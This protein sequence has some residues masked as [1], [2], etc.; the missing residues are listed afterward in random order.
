MEIQMTKSKTQQT[1]ASY[2]DG[3]TRAF[4]DVGAKVQ[5]PEAAR[6]FFRTQAATASQRAEDLHRQ[7]KSLADQSKTAFG[8]FAGSFDTVT[9]AMLDASLANTQ[10]YFATIEKLADANSVGEALTIQADYVR[11]ATAAN[12]ERIRTGADQ[13]K[14]L[15][16]EN[17]KV[18]QEQVKKAA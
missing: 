15:M 1:A 8:P 12:M 6:D 10:H 18:V 11:E 17:A 9:R 7:A 4:D 5:V 16:A 13:A 14:T 2:F 3:F